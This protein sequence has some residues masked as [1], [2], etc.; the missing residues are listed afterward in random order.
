MRRTRPFVLGGLA[1]AALAAVVAATSC[2]VYTRASFDVQV[3][4]DYRVRTYQLRTPLGIAGETMGSLGPH[5][6]AAGRTVDRRYETWLVQ[7][8]RRVARVVEDI[9]HPAAARDDGRFYA[10]L[11]PGA[12]PVLRVV[13]VR[14]GQTVTYDVSR[15]APVFWEG[16]DVVRLVERDRGVAVTFLHEIRLEPAFLAG[17]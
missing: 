6:T 10:Y 5:P 14:D 12:D 16:P 1:A 15:R 4:A 3:G 8:E 17:G 13:R 11:A 7:G 2:H 9:G